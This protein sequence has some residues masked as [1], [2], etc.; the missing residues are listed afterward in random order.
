MLVGTPIGNLDDLTPRAAAALATAE[1]IACEDTRRTG[2]LLTHLGLAAP[3]LLVANDHTEPDVAHEVVERIAAGQRVV[4]VTDAGM[5]G[6]SDPGEALVRAVVD[7]GFAV[8]IVPGPSAL[9]TALVISGLP[10]GRFCFEGFLPRKGSARRARLAA[11]AGE[12]RT[13]VVYEAP[14]RL[15]RTVADLHDVCGGDRR[16]AIVRELTK[17]H[18]EH[19]RGSLA[20]ARTMVD[21]RTPRGEYVLVVDGAEPPAAA[22]DGTLRA[23]FAAERA[24]GHST[25]DAVDTVAERFGVPRRRVYELAIQAY[26]GTDV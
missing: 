1:I 5:P 26:T 10:A 21:E 17:V 6:I 14:H 15:Q 18:E 22:D 13:V 23:A 12:E 9:D 4:V 2:R 25:R 19:W 20:E 8:E 7:A 24:A 11:I 16:V 3:K